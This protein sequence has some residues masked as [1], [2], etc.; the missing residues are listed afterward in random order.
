MTQSMDTIIETSG[1]FLNK[2]GGTKKSHPLS[3]L[4]ES[5]AKEGSVNKTMIHAK[6]R[7]KL[8]W[9]LEVIRWRIMIY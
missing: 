5:I 6:N 8:K 7:T 1:S 4:R 3:C 2:E 9:L